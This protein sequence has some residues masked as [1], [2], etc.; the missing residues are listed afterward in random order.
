[1]YKRQVF[2]HPSGFIFI[3]LDGRK[4]L[5][6]D[7]DKVTTYIG[8]KIQNITTESGIEKFRKWKELNDKDFRRFSKNNRDDALDLANSFKAIESIVMKK[9][10][11]SVEAEN[12]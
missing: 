6:E 10:M 4:I 2:D 5:L 12:E 8:E 3:E 7:A 11:S 9:D 1:M